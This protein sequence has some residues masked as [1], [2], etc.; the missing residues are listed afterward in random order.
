MW[1][2]QEGREEIVDV[3]PGI[4][5]TI[6]VDSSFQFRAAAQGYLSFI[7]VSMSPWPGPGEAYEVE[8]HWTPSGRRAGQDDH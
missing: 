7:G 1:R 8:G 4:C 3:E 5:L 6:P 2:R